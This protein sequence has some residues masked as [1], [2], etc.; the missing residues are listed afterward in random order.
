MAQRDFPQLVV[1]QPSRISYAFIVAT[2]VFVGWL[3]LATP[4]LATLFAYLALT[5]LHFLKGR[6]KWLAIVFFLLLVS[7]VS[8]GL[9]YSINQAVKTLPEIADTAIPS[10][11][12]LARE[13]QIE[14]PFTDYD[15]LKDMAFDAVKSQVHYLSSFANFARGA[16]KQFVFLILGVVVAI[17]LFLNPRLELDRE[18]H[19]I[20]NNL[21]SLC[22]DEIAA[23]FKAFYR[24]FA[25][26][27][28]AQVTIAVIN[29]AL[30]AIFVA[31]VQLP[32]AVVIIGLTFLCGLLPVIGNLISNTII[33]GIGF[34]LSPRM[35]LA[36]LVFLV[37]VHKLEYFLNS[38]IIGERIRNP[39]WL[40]L[41]ALVV[42]EKLMGVPGMILAPVV[43]NYIRIEAS[44]IEVRVDGPHDSS[45]PNS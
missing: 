21:Y 7:A 4:L 20:R 19:A 1:S 40:T 27:M 31:A 41:L 45:S 15:S 25:I 16:T 5:R 11:I 24:S 13:H 44:D 39:L 6:G 35:A 18:A 17:S 12:Q 43:L 42:G 26:V 37:V 3:Q 30:T 32:Y 33:V 9:A 36:A 34:T 2:L 29:T 38:K 8:Y 22:C 10:I 28:G 14:L 23:R